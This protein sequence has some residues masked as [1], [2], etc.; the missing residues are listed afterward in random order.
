[1]R[2]MDIRPLSR[3]SGKHEED[4][5]QCWICLQTG[6]PE[7]IAPCQCAGSMRWVHRPCLNRWRIDAA[8]PRNFTH[9]RHC[10]FGFCLKLVRQCS[11][12]EEPLRLRRQR[13]VRSAVAHFL[14]T[15]FAVQL[16]LAILA[17]FLRYLDTDERIVEFYHFHPSG[18][19]RAADENPYV[20]ALKHHKCE[21]YLTAA[22][23]TLFCIGLGNVLN[24][25]FKLCT[26]GDPNGARSWASTGDGTSS[27]CCSG[28]D[29]CPV[30]AQDLCECCQ[31]CC[32]GVDCDCEAARSMV[33][34]CVD[35]QGCGDCGD[36]GDC[37]CCGHCLVLLFFIAAVLCILL[38]VVFVLALL[39]VWLQQV[40]TRYVQLKELRCLAGE[41]VVQDLSTI[42]WRSDSG[43]PLQADINMPQVRLRGPASGVAVQQS[44]NRDLQA[45]YGSAVP[46]PS[47]AEP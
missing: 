39:V 10:G 43:V 47:A 23:I 28:C 33:P 41:Y 6:G 18:P 34:G 16:F 12:E 35:C 36:C 13:L 2:D 3:T 31:R 9:C 15:A 45:V 25:C 20:Y 11:E 42:T 21:Y 1:M 44:L 17:A 38:G 37:C 5:R 30:C 26:R 14:L 4:E 32:L 8:N 24:L 22:L 40:F 29:G 46:P 7:L 27:S 19:V